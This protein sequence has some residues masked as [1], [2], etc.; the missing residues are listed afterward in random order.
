ME[1]ILPEDHIIYTSS[2]NMKQICAPLK[3]CFDITHFSYVQIYPDLSRI[4]LDTNAIWSEVFYKNVHQYY[5]NTGVT[6]CQHWSSGF[7]LMS[8]LAEKDCITDARQFDIGNGIVIAHHSNTQTELYF[9]ALPA[10]AQE[11]SLIRILTHLDLIHKFINYFKVRSANI[12]EQAS[13]NPIILPFLKESKVV[14]HFSNEIRQSFINQLECEN[15]LNSFFT[16]RELDCIHYLTLGMTCREIGEILQISHRT[17][18]HYLDNIKTKLGV[19][20]KSQIVRKITQMN[21]ANCFKKQV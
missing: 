3:N 16:K 21:M 7:A 17:V 5:L 1:I 2:S 19:L 13:K 6:E 4:H 20:K 18:E 8:S 12:I 14:N 15:W 10:N 9:F 11:A